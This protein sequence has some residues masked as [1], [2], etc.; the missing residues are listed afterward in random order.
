[1]GKGRRKADSPVAGVCAQKAVWWSVRAEQILH[2]EYTLAGSHCTLSH[3]SGSL[4]AIG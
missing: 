4:P 1:M 3:S 2:L